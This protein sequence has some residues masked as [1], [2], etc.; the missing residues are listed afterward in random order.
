VGAR[1]FRVMGPTAGLAELVALASGDPVANLG[2]ELD[3]DV[4]APSATAAA[5]VQLELMDR[6]VAA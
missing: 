2:Q 3:L 6:V 4:A 5:V 1:F